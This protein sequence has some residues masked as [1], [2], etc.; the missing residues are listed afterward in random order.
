MISTKFYKR[1]QLIEYDY[2]RLPC[3][4]SPLSPGY[5]ACLPL[6][7]PFAHTNVYTKGARS[8]NLS[9][10]R[11]KRAL[12]LS[13]TLLVL[14]NNLLLN[15]RRNLLILGELHAEGTAP[16]RNRAQIGGIMQHLGLRNL[17]RD[18]LH[19]VA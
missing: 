4:S 9:S 15:I 5:N 14:C 11:G 13:L 6:L 1:C 7:A 10:S 2:T 8:K 16:L 18:T 3:L 12:L 19:T 17:C